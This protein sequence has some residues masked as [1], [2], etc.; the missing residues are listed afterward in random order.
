MMKA[1]QILIT[2]TAMVLTGVL[3]IGGTLAYL[4][5]TT[6]TKKNVFSSSKDLDGK[7]EETFDEKTASDYTPGDVIEKVPT[8]KNDSN[9][10]D[11]YAAVKITCIDADGNEISIDEFKKYGTFDILEHWQPIADGIYAYADKDA[12]DPTKINLLTLEAGKSTSPVFAEVKVNTG[13]EKVSTTS[14]SGKVVYKQNEDG[15][16]EIVS[17]SSEVT[18]DTKYYTV[19]V[20]ANGKKTYT[21]T[22]EGLTE[23]LPSFRIDVTGYMVQSEGMKEADAITELLA[24]AQ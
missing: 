16:Y 11:A 1:K 19:T 4:S 15:K 10:I 22:T 18:E 14:E 7:I 8:L 24:L 21:E 9:N 20:D 17:E 23:K 3:A 6:E 13:I 2:V 5:T 12:N